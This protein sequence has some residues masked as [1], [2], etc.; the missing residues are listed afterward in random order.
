M[1][2]GGC[3]KAQGLRYGCECVYVSACR[4]MSVC[5]CATWLCV[6]ERLCV[7]N[8]GLLWVCAC[9]C[10]RVQV[11]VGCVGVIGCVQVGGCVRGTRIPGILVCECQAC[12][13]MAWSWKDIQLHDR[14]L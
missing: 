4:L 13:G 2:C 7:W 3:V 1:M 10:G 6:H 12:Q 5:V 14:V 9:V 11:L 8:C